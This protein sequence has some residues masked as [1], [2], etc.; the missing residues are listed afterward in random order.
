MNDGTPDNGARAGRT[1]T[2]NHCEELEVFL[3]VKCAATGKVWHRISVDLV[4]K[5]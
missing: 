1:V 4:S 2:T 3:L 5:C